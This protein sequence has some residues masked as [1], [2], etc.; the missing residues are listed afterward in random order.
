MSAVGSSLH[1]Q[2]L[3][4]DIQYALKRAQER[5]ASDKEIVFALERMGHNTHNTADIYRFLWHESAE[6]C[7]II[8]R[9]WHK[10]ICSLVVD[11]EELDE[12][13]ARVAELESCIND[14][15]RQ[16]REQRKREGQSWQQRGWRYYWRTLRR[17][18]ETWFPP[19][20]H[21]AY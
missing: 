16:N 8:R 12:A 7:G 14:L 4:A 2:S 17:R 19:R 3:S 13:L 11:P 9:M 6:H 15:E 21:T 1:N 18:Y 20:R 10:D 5:G